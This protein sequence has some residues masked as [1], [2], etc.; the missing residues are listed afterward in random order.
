MKSSKIN[1]SNCLSDHQHQLVEESALYFN[2]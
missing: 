2:I 1:Q